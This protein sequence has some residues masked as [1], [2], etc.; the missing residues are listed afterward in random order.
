MNLTGLGRMYLRPGNLWKCYRLFRKM[1]RIDGGYP[2]E[3]YEETGES[4]IGVLAKAQ[5]SESSRMKLMWD[6]REHSLS[7]TMV[8]R[9]KANVKLGDMLTLGG[10]AWLVLYNDDVGALGVAGLL[11]L[12]ERND[13]K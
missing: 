11:Y 4:V 12:E 2:K 7:H 9:G 10:K 6:Q 13:V 3:E 5:D 8:V 1:T